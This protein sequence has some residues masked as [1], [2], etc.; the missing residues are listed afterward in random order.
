LA[1]EDL[2]LQEAIDAR[3]KIYADAADVLAIIDA[4]EDTISRMNTWNDLASAAGVQFLK[5]KNQLLTDMAM[6]LAGVKP[7]PKDVAAS[8][9]IYF[10]EIHGIIG[11]FIKAVNKLDDPNPENEESKEEDELEIKNILTRNDQ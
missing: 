2:T 10:G 5:V 3:K 8:Y 9:D 4:L 11:K 7:G 6:E 1:A